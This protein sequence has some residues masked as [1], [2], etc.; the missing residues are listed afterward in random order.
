MPSEPY[1][2]ELR[3]H[4]RGF[5]FVDHPDR[6]SVFVPAPLLVGLLDGDVIAGDLRPGTDQAD[7][8]SLVSRSR[9]EVFGLVRREKGR[10]SLHVD[11]ACGDLTLPLAGAN[12]LPEGTAVRAALSKRGAQTLEH[13]TDP[14]EHAALAARILTRHRLPTGHSSASSAEASRVA[15]RRA[16]DNHHRRDLTHQLV[17]TIDDD[18]SHDLDDALAAA[19]AHNGGLRVWVHVADVAEHVH[20]N[21][22][23]DA[24][25]ASTTTSVYLPEHVVHMFP[26][27][28]SAGRLSLLPEQERDVLTVELLIDAE[29]AVRSVDLYESRIRSRQRLNYETVTSVICKPTQ[30]AKTHPHIAPDIVA[31]TGQ[32]WAAATRLSALRSTRGGLDARRTDPEPAGARG[33][34]EGH[35]LVERLMVAANEAVGSWLNERGVTALYRVHPALTDDDAAELEQVASAL[36][37]HAALPRPITPRALSCLADAVAH[38]QHADAFWQSLMGLLSKAAY[39]D[40]PG[41]HFGLGSS[42]YLHFTSPLRRYADLTVHRQVKSYLAGDRLG[43]LPDARSLALHI[44][45]VSRRAAQAE[46]DMRRAL[47]LRDIE[48]G[49]RVS[50]TVIKSGR[51]S[52]ALVAGTAGSL[53]SSSRRP[54]DVIRAK[55]TLSDPLTGRLE[56]QDLS[57]PSRTRRSRTSRTSTLTDLTKSPGLPARARTASSKSKAG[58]EAPERPVSSRPRPRGRRRAPRTEPQ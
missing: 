56:L 13:W 7:S 27:A 44:T 47:A 48:E 22:T 36:G 2:G 19:P 42:C 21:S 49:S 8:V 23:L 57:S 25:A 54:G 16:S 38:V 20:P 28:L 58:V 40:A 17:I 24:A 5:G 33:E 53:V 29:G 32:L 12:R 11:P 1:E 4:Y 50:A 3:V 52:R 39:S 41:L 43:S 45:Q 34:T 46:R 6:P 51:Q 30:V 9:S 31:M 35:L 18:H 26:P 14:L 15:S 10:T 37:V 55:V